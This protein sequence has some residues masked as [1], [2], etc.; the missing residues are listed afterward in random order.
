M[1]KQLS[2]IILSVL[3][4]I[5]FAGCKNQGDSTETTYRYVEGV[6]SDKDWEQPTPSTGE[7]A[8]PDRE[9]AISI[10][11]EEFKKLQDSGIGKTYVL[12]GVFYDTADEV[13]VVSF[14]E[15]SEMP[16]SCYNIAVSKASGEIIKQ[17][18]SE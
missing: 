13:W 12:K 11:S 1:R 14:G 3:I 4:L 6:Y 17:W 16:G 18:P 9:T 5:L 7:S 10:A 8:A 2:I 15:N